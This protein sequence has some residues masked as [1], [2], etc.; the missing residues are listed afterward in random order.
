MAPFGLGQRQQDLALL[1]G[2]SRGEL[3]VDRSLGPLLCQVTS[4]TANL[5]GAWRTRR[6][7]LRLHKDSLPGRSAAA[8][9]KSA[10]PPAT[11]TKAA[12]LARGTRRSWTARRTR[13][14]TEPLRP[15]LRDH[16]LI[17]PPRRPGL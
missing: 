16:L 12:S 11:C 2:T 8:P 13:Q 15:C 10:T 6:S 5:D 9:R 1:S 7:G 17:M 4:P 3:G 14:G